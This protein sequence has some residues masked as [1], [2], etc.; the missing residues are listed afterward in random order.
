MGTHIEITTYA[1]KL[2]DE[3]KNTERHKNFLIDSFI[4]IL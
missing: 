4:Y 1:L 3:F 2:H